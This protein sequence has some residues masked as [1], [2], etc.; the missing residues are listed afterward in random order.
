M[1][2]DSRLVHVDPIVLLPIS[3]R[4]DFFKYYVDEG[5]THGGV[6]VPGFSRFVAGKSVT[7]EVGFLGEEMA[8]QAAAVVRSRGTQAA[9]GSPGTLMEF[10]PESCRSRDFA[11]SLARGERRPLRQQHRRM[12]IVMDVECYGEGHVVSGRT[13]NLSMGGA[14]LEVFRSLP[15]GE[16][17]ELDLANE[18]QV[19]ATVMWSRPRPASMGLK[20]RY[21]NASEQQ[22]IQGLLEAARESVIVVL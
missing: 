3:K 16:K 19:S 10:V 21:R 7:L 8:I 9:S 18:V 4:Q 22:E 20:F 14:S 15:V 2:R 6:F 5:T 1:L 13:R 11:L 12:P 17:V